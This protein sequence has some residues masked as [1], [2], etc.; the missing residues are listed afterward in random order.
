[1][2]FFSFQG[3]QGLPPEWQKA[4]E[5]SNLEKDAIVKNIPVVLNC[6]EYVCRNQLGD[7]CEQD[8]DFPDAAGD[9]YALHSPTDVSIIQDDPAKYYRLQDGSIGEGGYS[10]V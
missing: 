6:L 7:D 9:S 5:E 1:M 2:P 10:K 4:L 8:I 3:L